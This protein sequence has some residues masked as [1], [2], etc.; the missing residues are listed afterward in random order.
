M[1]KLKDI[2]KEINEAVPPIGGV[3]L[4]GATSP[5]TVGGYDPV[6]MASSYMDGVIGACNQLKKVLDDVDMHAIHNKKQGY[7]RETYNVDFLIRNIKSLMND[8]EEILVKKSNLNTNK[9]IEPK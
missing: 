8:V 6:E 9:K 2:I 7:F 5:P 4:G 1:K 3:P